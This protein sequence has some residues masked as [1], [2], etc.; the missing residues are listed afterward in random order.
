M[1]RVATCLRLALRCQMDGLPHFS[2]EYIYLSPYHCPRRE[3]LSLVQSILANRS[4]TPT[5][6][7]PVKSRRTWRTLGSIT[8]PHLNC[9]W[10]LL[11][12][13]AAGRVCQDVR[14]QVFG[15]MHS[16]ARPPCLP[17]HWC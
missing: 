5:Y 9:V 4:T 6:F 14:R 10:P 7:S 12:G 8:E 13:L 3:G 15:I 17:V 2:P 11:G 1:L 16:T